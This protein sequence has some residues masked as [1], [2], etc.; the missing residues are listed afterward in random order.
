MPYAFVLMPFDETSTA[1]YT[2]FIGP[3]LEAALSQNCHFWATF[4]TSG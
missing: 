3:T 1:L 2:D 4:G